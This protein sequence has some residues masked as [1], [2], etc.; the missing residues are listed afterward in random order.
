MYY[1]IVLLCTSSNLEPYWKSFVRDKKTRV[2]RDKNKKKI[3][4]EYFIYVH[5]GV[6]IHGVPIHTYEYKPGVSA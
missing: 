5:I 1:N 6:L 3:V 4:F 2:G